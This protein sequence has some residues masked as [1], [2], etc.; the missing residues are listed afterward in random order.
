MTAVTYPRPGG[1]RLGTTF[2][3]GRALAWNGAREGILPGGRNMFR[4]AFSTVYSLCIPCRHR[5]HN[6]VGR[7]LTAGVQEIYLVCARC[8]KR[9]SPGVQFGPGSFRLAQHS[10]SAPELATVNWLLE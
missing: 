10:S 7:K 3:L 9:V 2:R 5:R 1:I 6:V 8:G 4:R